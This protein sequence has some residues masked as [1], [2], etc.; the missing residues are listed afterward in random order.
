LDDPRPATQIAA[1]A[2]NGHQIDVSRDEIDERMGRE[3]C[4]ADCPRTAT[5]I[6]NYRIVSDLGANFID[7]QPGS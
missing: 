6:D 7:N 5:Q 2:L 4:S 1:C 3:Q